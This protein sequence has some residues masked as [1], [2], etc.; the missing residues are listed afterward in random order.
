VKSSSKYGLQH[1][2]N[3]E[4]VRGNASTQLCGLC[5]NKK[6]ELAGGNAST[7]PTQ[8]WSETPSIWWQMSTISRLSDSSNIIKENFSKI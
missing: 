5:H 8:T 6:S 2:K 4:Q 1:N 7:H 3:L